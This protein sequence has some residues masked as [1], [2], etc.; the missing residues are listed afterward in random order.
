MI[1]IFIALLLV[2]VVYL[3]IRLIKIQN[4]IYDE[5]NRKIKNKLKEYEDIKQKTTQAITEEE[6][7]N[8]E[9]E[10][11]KEQIANAIQTVEELTKNSKKLADEKMK[12]ELDVLRQERI[13]KIQQEI[14]QVEENA[15]KTKKE[16]NEIIDNLRIE[17]ADY[18]AKRT[19]IIAAQKRELEL[20]NQKDFHS[21]IL[22]NNTIE[23]IAFI[24]EIL[25]KVHKK[26]IIAKVI[27][28]SYLQVPTKEML[29]RVVGKEKI[30]GI[31]RITNIKNQQCYVGQGV[32]IS[33]RLIQHIKGTL[34]IQSIADQ[35]IHHIMADEGLENWTFEILEQCN[36]DK[37]NEREKYWINFYK[38]DEF[39]YNKTAG[40]AAK[41]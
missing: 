16:L 13:Q 4:G 3:I 23:D 2:L 11:R 1:Y 7:A 25:T 12:V 6:K 26:E 17:L 10:K 19:A 5:V 35:R 34:G 33:N 28:E 24:K 15:T 40:G 27:W 31:Y 8:Q 41:R 39:G 36:K 14:A 38:S 29:N 30:S 22:D 9:L 21:I 32:D 20:Q 37:L 18:E